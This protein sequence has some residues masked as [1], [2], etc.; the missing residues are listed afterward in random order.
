M[1]QTSFVARYVN[2]GNERQLI[3]VGPNSDAARN[4]VDEFNRTPRTF[5]PVGDTYRITYM[6]ES[7]Q[8]AEKFFEEDLKPNLDSAKEEV[9]P[10]AIPRKRLEEIRQEDGSYRYLDLQRLV[11]A[12]LTE[13]YHGKLPSEDLVSLDDGHGLE[14]RMK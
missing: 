7:M 5:G 2:Y 6:V 10:V 3:L 12:V 4:V 11:Q 9:K 8:G 1:G 14:I 13:E